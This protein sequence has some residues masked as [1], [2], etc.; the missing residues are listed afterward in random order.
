MKKTAVGLLT[1]FVASMFTVMF[2]AVPIARATYTLTVVSDTDTVWYDGT[3]WQSAVACWVHGSWPTITGATW[4]WRTQYTDPAWEYANV[5]HHEDGDYWIFRRTFT[6]PEGA[7]DFSGMLTTITADN[8]YEIYINGVYVGGD[9]ALNKDGPDTQQWK[10][11]EQYIGFT[12]LSGE[13]VIEIRSVN[14]FSYGTYSS[15]PAGLIYKVDV[16]YEM[17]IEV[18]IDIKPGSDP[19][20]IC[21]SDQGN[22][23]IAILGTEDF[24]VTTIDPETIL[25]GGVD[26]AERGS[27]KRP[28]LAYS[29]E[30]ASGPGGTPDG[31]LDLMAFFSVQE[32]ITANALTEDTT[33]LT[34]DANLYAE[35]G[36]TPITGTDSVRVVPP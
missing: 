23:P 1:L 9:G 13:N 3:A 32:L 24:D 28:K 30:D 14:F 10:S 20:S 8:A 36:A 26:L 19:N 31:Y 11:I 27:P 6:L 15:N 29:F 4:I 34:L 33:A 17:P 5:P 2:N 22:L 7:Y 25:L 18:N 35:H 16:S 21:L 12:P